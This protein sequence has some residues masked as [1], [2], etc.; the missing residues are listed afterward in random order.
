VALAA[1]PEPNFIEK[2]VQTNGA[3]IAKGEKYE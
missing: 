2:P 3:R 1:V